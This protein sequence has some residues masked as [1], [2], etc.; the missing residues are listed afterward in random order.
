M[1]RSFLQELENSLYIHR[2]LPLHTERSLEAGFAAK[3][4]TDRRVLYGPGTAV[5]APAAANEGEVS[6]REGVITITAPLRSDHWPEGAP[7]D[8][9]YSNFGTASVR[10]RFEP[11]SWQ[12][13]HRLR[14]WARPRMQ[15][16]RIA[17]LNV[18]VKNVGKIPLPDPYFREGATVFDLKN[19][20]WNECIW[21]FAAMP[22]DAVCEVTFYVFLSGQDL[23]AGPQLVYDYRDIALEAIESPEHEHGWQPRTG[24]IT[25]ST[26]G[27]WPRGRKTAVASLAADRFELVDAAT[28]RA[29][30]CGP[31]R[32]E[33]NPR[34][35]FAVLDFSAC[36]TPGRYYLRAGGARSAE[37]AIEE[38]LC[39]ES[40]WKVLNF[41]YCERC[42][43]PV[44]GR[45]GT[46]HLDVTARHGGVS[47]PFAGGWHDAGDVSQ[48]AAQTG[49]VVHALFENAQRCKNDRLLYLRL[50]E[51]A[52]WGLD[53]IL[54]T[55]FG[56]GFRATSA[57]ATRFTN[58]LAG[59]F[60]DIEARVHDHSFENFLC[61]GV[62][63]YAAFCLA[64]YDP[65][66][67]EGSL[68]AARQDFGF[69]MEKFKRTGV[70]PAHM[71]EHTYNSGLSQYYAVIVWAAS[72]LYQ[73]GGAAEHAAAA[74]KY[75]RKLLDCQ[76]QGAAGM[77]LT[78]FF[79]RDESHRVIVHFN[80]QSREQQFM[81]ALEALCRTQPEAA[82][83]PA[84]ERAMRLYGGYLKAIAPGTAP[85]GMLPAGVHRTDEAQDAETFRWL[86]VAADYEAE[87][88]NY[89]EQLAQGSPVAPGYVLRNFPVWFSFRGNT[90]VMLAMGKAASLLGRYFGDE[91]L[92]QLGREQLYWMWGKNP[93][94]QSLIYGAGSNYCRQYAVLC[95][96]CAGEV[97]VGVETLGNEDVP[98]WP[99]NNNA[100]FREVWVGAA[101]RWLW[102]C[103][104]YLGE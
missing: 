62:E 54:R 101:C 87:K 35:S 84:W 100:T 9:D 42:G 33:Q 45:H 39:K 26:V 78:G 97:P 3:A 68:E 11:Q 34:G 96:E 52:Q 104:D 77:G 13:F 90:A 51:E 71:F 19:N 41:F 50:M 40:L 15:G 31:V 70:D 16:G 98:Y 49:E 85:Y 92:L 24:D 59:D 67:A 94:G 93:F 55:R 88:R 8:G 30:F 23:A 60:D 44:Q 74:R 17:H 102:L 56:D 4:V 1:D 61:A 72:C 91:E 18:S 99:Q 29:V 82:E 14:F 2:P 76:E 64:E 58:G 80:H 69:A 22:R 57:G 66:L 37:F 48:Q 81:Q 46:C 28:G 83:R 103:A 36:E 27:Y 65:G 6:E 12:A 47:L 38:Q 5:A 86:H 63:A 89:E 53:F 10:L 7:A 32:Q 73:A 43:T 95:G 25:L 21:E 20:Q 79:Y 75:A